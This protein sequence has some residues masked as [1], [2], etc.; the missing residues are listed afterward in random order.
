MEETGGDFLHSL[1]GIAIFRIISMNFLFQK[2][3]EKSKPSLYNAGD[4]GTINEYKEE[5]VTI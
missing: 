3:R 1:R 4:Y 2:D 5:K